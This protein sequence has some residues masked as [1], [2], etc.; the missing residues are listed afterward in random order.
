M[1]RQKVRGL[2]WHLEVHMLNSQFRKQGIVLF[3]VG[4]ALFGCGGGG[5][6][7]SGSS[8][9]ATF[10]GQMTMTGGDLV[11]STTSGVTQTLQ[12]KDVNDNV[13]SIP[14]VY[15][16]DNLSFTD[17][18]QVVVCKAGS[19][20]CSGHY[21]S[22]TATYINRNT[23]LTKAVPL[24]ANG[25]L[26]QDTVVAGSGVIRLPIDTIGNFSFPNGIEVTI[27]STFHTVQTVSL[28][29]SAS[30]TLPSGSQPG[31]NVSCTTTFT[32]TGAPTG[33]FALAFSGTGTISMASLGSSPVTNA[34]TAMGQSTQFPTAGVAYSYYN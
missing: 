9:R 32:G 25:T 11:G 4:A 7:S 16:P 31:T 30:A 18:G 21:T 34:G 33:G 15:S 2:V 29:N 13:T 27:N 26:A 19:S 23:G 6:S 22:Q 12:V 5:G 1:S 10:S 8:M 17:T 3:V 20:L 24:N 28:T 14:A